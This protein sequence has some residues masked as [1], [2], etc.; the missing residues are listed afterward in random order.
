MLSP[1]P[2][3]QARKNRTELLAE[4]DFKNPNYTLVFKKRIEKLKQIR[5]D[6]TVLPGLYKFYQDNPAKFIIDWGTTYDPRNVDRGLPAMIPFI[7]FPKQEEF[8]EWII[9]RWR[10]REPG[11]ADKSR[12]MGMSWLTIAVACTLCLFMRGMSIGFGSRKEEY[13]DKIGDPKSLLYKARKFVALLPREFRMG[14]DIKRHAP[15]MR[16]YFPYSD[17][18]I[19]GEAGDGIGRGD[20][21]SIYIVDEAAFLPRPELVEASLSETTNCRIDISTPRG[22]ANPFAKKRFSGKIKTFSLHWRDDPRKDDAW[23]KRRCDYIDDPVIIAQELDLDYTASVAR[24]LI[25]SAWVQAAIDAHIKLGVKPTGVRTSGFDVADEGIDEDAFAGRD[26]IL[27]DYLESWSGVGSDI[28]KS[29]EQV[30]TL[31]GLLGYE[32]VRYDAD[33]LGAGVR[34]DARIITERRAEKGIIVNLPFIPFQGSASVLDPEGDPFLNSDKL[35]NNDE[36]DRTNE[37]FFANAKA[38]G[39]WFLR[40][41]FQLTY[42]AVVEGKPFNPD[43]IISIAS[44]CPERQELMTELSQPTYSLNPVGKILVDKG[45]KSPNRADAVMIVFAPSEESIRGFWDA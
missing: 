10:N 14:W 5:K 41:R 37:D 38:Q 34:G 2:Q 20:R 25:P 9:N 43:N 45:I 42:R 30:F 44:N 22:M 8:V 27:I 15:H 12:D 18:I 35:K 32:S 21:T 17:S 13:V 11:V 24:V 36:L 3:K 31:C 23:Y 29:V 6:P 40:R 1:P 16:I 4:F 7:L 19:S 39:W 28:Y 26:G 33:G